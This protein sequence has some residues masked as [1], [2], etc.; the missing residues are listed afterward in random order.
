MK[1]FSI[2]P[3]TKNSITIK[4]K[5]EN[6]KG[7]PIS[8]K[9]NLTKQ[10]HEKKIL[11]I[12]FNAGDCMPCIDELLTKI[13]CNVYYILGIVGYLTDSQIENIKNLNYQF[14]ILL[15]REYKLMRQLRIRLTPKTYILKNNLEIIP[16]NQN[17]L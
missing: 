8:L 2:E 13:D 6:L 12:I 14:E 5:W 1:L 7:E 9:A 15:D 3:I 4:N 17:E 11:L 16:I 10:P